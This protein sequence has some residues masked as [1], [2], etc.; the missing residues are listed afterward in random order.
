MLALLVSSFA[1]LMMIL[2]MGRACARAMKFNA[3][4]PDVLFLGFAA[5]NTAC[6]WFSLGFPVGFSLMLVLSACSALY[7]VV[8]ARDIRGAWGRVQ[9]TFLFSAAILVVVGIAF[10]AASGRATNFDTLL[11]HL[12]TIRWY[13]TYP[14]VPGLANLDGPLAYNQ[15]VFLL[16]ALTSFR[17]VFGSEVFSVNFVVF[18][19]FMGYLMRR[20]LDLYQKEGITLPWFFY[21]SLAILVIRMPNLSAPS[22]DFL[23]QVLPLYI[24]LR[25]LDLFMEGEVADKRALHLLFVLA[26]YCITVKLTSAPILLL[27]LLFEIMRVGPGIWSYFRM[28]PA[29]LLIIAPWL[30]R[31]VV[32]SG[33]LVYPF[34]QLDLF[35]FDWKVPLKDVVARK[36][37]VTVWARVPVSGLFEQNIG[38][39][40]SVWFPLWL[41]YGKNTPFQ[42]LLMALGF[43]F[44]MA[45]L[46]AMWARWVTRRSHLTALLITCVIGMQFWFWSSPSYRLGLCMIAISALSPLL[47]LPPGNY[48]SL[49]RFGRISLL[50]AYAILSLYMAYVHLHSLRQLFD[51]TSIETGQFVKQPRMQYVKPEFQKEKGRNFEYYHPVP[52]IGCYDFELPCTATADSTLMMRGPTLRE[53]FRKVK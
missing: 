22:P 19:I 5:L 18:A 51:G 44:P 41:K 40:I 28:G 7:L 46:L 6:A 15:N 24:I 53:G 10:V 2:A 33:W 23:S 45:G 35:S 30:T 36:N 21:L 29:A 50:H 1:L 49:G 38:K 20:L 39:G 31:Y 11:Y 16:Y 25:M 43:L 52:D 3:S 26:C 27:F 34:P 4:L 9:S 47:W 8:S 32:M 48:G 37:A 13:E 42:L 14:V 17:Q 12:P